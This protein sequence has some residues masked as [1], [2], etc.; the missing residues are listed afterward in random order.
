VRLEIQKMLDSGIIEPVEESEWT[1][2]MVVQDKKIKEIRICVDLRKLNDAC[3]T[4]PFPTPFI[5]EVLDNVGGHEAYSFTDGFLGYHQIKIAKEDR[6]KTTFVMK[7]ACYQYT[8]MPFGLKNAP[9]IFSR[10]VVTTFQEFIH[11]FLEVYFDAWT[12]FGLLN[13]H[14][15]QLRLMFDRCRQCQIALNLKKYIFCSP[16]GILLGHVVCK[17]GLIVDLAKIAIIVNLPPP[18]S[19]RQLRTTL[20][21]TGYYKFFIKGCA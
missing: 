2:H 15:E 20:G 1:S 10:V 19:V 18:T 12:V 9:A 17:Q 6:H 4:D 8:F 5:D 16:F 14:I 13:N 11:K 7:E 21:H 3:L